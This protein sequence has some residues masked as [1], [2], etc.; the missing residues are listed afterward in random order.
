MDWVLYFHR[1]PLYVAHYARWCIGLSSVGFLKIVHLPTSCL[2]CVFIWTLRLTDGYLLFS[3]LVATNHRAWLI[4][5]QSVKMQLHVRG[6][7]THVLDVQPGDSISHVKVS[8]IKLNWL[9]QISAMAI[10]SHACRMVVV[11]ILEPRSNTRFSLNS[12]RMRS[13]CYFLSIICCFILNLK[14]KLDS[15]RHLQWTAESSVSHRLDSL[16]SLLE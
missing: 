15:W 13:Q 10:S 1:W 12:G 9:N 3:V 5:S 7:N 2:K 11:A 16:E 8:V 14:L 4:L 6:L